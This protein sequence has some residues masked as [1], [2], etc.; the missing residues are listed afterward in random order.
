[1]DVKID[2]LAKMKSELA[3]VYDGL[4]DGRLTVSEAHELNKA[5]GKK[6]ESLR[7]RIKVLSGL[8]E[9]TSVCIKYQGMKEAGSTN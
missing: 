2:E 4:K 7:A 8:R 9:L 6:I 1:M 5:A 3:E